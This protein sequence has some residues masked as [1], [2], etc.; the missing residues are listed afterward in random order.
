MKHTTILILLILPICLFA[1]EITFNGSAKNTV[2]V[3]E[4]F[5]VTYTV[6]ARSSDFTM[7]EIKD[8]NVL[9][10]VNQ[11]S[12]SS[13]QFI[14]G[15]MTSSVSCTYSFYLEATKEGTF[16]IPPATVKVN[17][18]K[19]ESNSI[20]ITVVKGASTAQQQ[21][22]KQQTQPPTQQETA[23]QAPLDEMLFTKTIVNKS[24]V[25]QGEEIIVT[26]KIY[27]RA[28]LVGL[29]ETKFP[30][31]TGF[32]TE[33]VDMPK[34]ISLTNE[35]INGVTYRVA[36]L[37][38]T[39]L[40]PQRSGTLEIE[41]MEIECIIRE[42]VKRRQPI[43]FWDDF[44]DMGFGYQDRNYKVKSHPVK[45]IV[46]PLPSANKPANFSEAVGNFNLSSEIDKQK[47]KTNEAVNLKITV[48]GEGNLELIGKF[49]I[50]FPTDFETYEPKVSDKIAV[51]ATGVSGKRTFEYLIIPRHEGIFT[52]PHVVFS[53]FNPEKNT[54]TTLSTPEYILEVEKGDVET[55]VTTTIT[56]ITKE[57]V[58][59]IGKD[60]RYIKTNP[61]LLRT[62]GEYFFGSMNFY[63]W[64]IIPV[65]IFL[66][67]LIIVKQ[68]MK[69][70]EALIKYR[71]ANKIAQQRLRKANKFLKQNQ[72]EKFHE[73]MSKCLWNY[74]S[75]KLQIP[76]SL[77]SKDNIL[78][79]L[80]QKAVS[81]ELSDELNSLLDYC[82]FARFALKQ[83]EADPTYDVTS[84][85]KTFDKAILLINEIERELK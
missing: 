19:I 35:V 29:G 71:R 57:D 61:F 83:D 84:M 58:K 40:F 13:F 5:R 14:N 53:Y 78:Q 43:S 54:Y 28:N 74:I 23:S 20:T 56:N 60:I 11:S 25:Y 80:E 31:Y 38:K 39:I 63:L 17:G 16:T 42:Q 3:G 50:P 33:E 47:V 15:Q 67:L 69:V 4:Q 59:F 27:T 55:S 37:K 72:K 36:E 85:N 2:A 34:Q 1:E 24:K 22:S 76:I 75:N 81:K 73:E 48:S 8:F 77:L 62:S 52:I 44:L 82:E 30:S 66:L 45:I 18:K 68:R 79:T 41:P 49:T 46:N 26:H 7:P 64:L 10:G 12:S 65:I 6:N 51:T 9:S 32:W 70:D 21:G